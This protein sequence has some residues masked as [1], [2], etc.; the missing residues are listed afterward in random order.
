[1]GAEVLG[2]D[3]PGPQSDN[4]PTISLGNVALAAG[5]K[6]PLRASSCG[7]G[8]NDFFRPPRR[9]LAAAYSPLMQFPSLLLFL[10]LLWPGHNR[11]QANVRTH[12]LVRLYPAMALAHRHGSVI[13][14]KGRESHPV[15]FTKEGFLG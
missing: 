8:G 5:L 13:H 1:M 10:I 15:I 9:P 11:G 7:S 12:D 14:I 6:L 4:R 2:A 3:E